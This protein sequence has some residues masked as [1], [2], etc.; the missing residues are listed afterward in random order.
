M[1]Q[2]VPAGESEQLL[3]S[4]PVDAERSAQQP[5]V[6]EPAGLGEGRQQQGVDPHRE[7]EQQ[8]GLHALAAGTAPVQAADQR[9]RELRDRRERHQAEGR[10]RGVTAAHPVIAVGHGR[11]TEDRDPAD[12][13]HGR[14]D[15]AVVALRPAAPEQRRHHQVVG[16]HG[17]QRH[18]GD[19]DHAGGRGEA[20][21]VGEQ[22][23]QVAA[24]G[25]RQAQHQG[26]GGIAGRAGAHRHAGGGDRQHRQRHQRQVAAE[27]PARPADV[28]DVHAFDHR[29]VELSRQADD[30]GEGQQRLADEADRRRFADQGSG[31]FA[32]VELAAVEPEHR[33]HAH[34]HQRHQLDHR[35]QRDRQHHARTV[36]GGIDLA[37]AV[38]DREQGHQHRHVQRRVADAGQQPVL[39]AQHLQAERH[40]LVLQREVGHRRDQRNEADQGRQ[41]LVAAV[42]RGDEVGDRDRALRLRH[43][44]Q[45]LEDAPAEQQHQQRAKV[46]REIADAIAGR[47]ADRAVEGPRRAVHRQRQAVDQRPQPA[48]AGAHVHRMAV[49]PPGHGEQQ[50]GVAQRHQQ[51]DPARQHPI[52]PRSL[53]DP[54]DLPGL[55]GSAPVG[56]AAAATTPTIPR[57]RSLQLAAGARPRRAHEKA[58]L[59][60]GF[61]G[62]CRACGLT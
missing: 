62:S 56:A 20:A 46:D 28:R 44:R 58:R 1:G 31:G 4:Q 5:R 12:P 9:R 24:F 38:E 3:R 7:A 47:G 13:E 37:G 57:S 59:S 6:V 33:E 2:R 53:G 19:D 10:Q 41:T 27:H 25:Q 23:Q 30:R 15:V 42:A 55:D 14:G 60:A 39:P 18:A 43:Q 34:R 45:A 35:L 52:S 26:V 51:Q 40:R 61:P 16:D 17:R 36:L 29:D 32:E 8:A 54:V 22:R 49:A 48:A 11:E 21:D 50:R